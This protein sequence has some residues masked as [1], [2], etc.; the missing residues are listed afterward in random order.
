MPALEGLK[1]ALQ[2]LYAKPISYLKDIG[3]RQSQFHLEKSE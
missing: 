2:I 1:R 3:N